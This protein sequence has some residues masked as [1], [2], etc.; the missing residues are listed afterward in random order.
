MFKDIDDM[1]G[2]A[3]TIG[4]VLTKEYC[5]CHLPGILLDVNVIDHLL[6]SSLDSIHL[7]GMLLC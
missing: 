3:T 7:N 6:V 2:F 5:A 4:W 1:Y